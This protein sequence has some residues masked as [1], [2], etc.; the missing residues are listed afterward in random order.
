MA[1]I[2]IQDLGQS[3]TLD[4]K[5]MKALS[6]GLSCLSGSPCHDSPYLPSFEVPDINA[7]LENLMKGR[8][9]LEGQPPTDGPIPIEDGPG[10]PV[11][12]AY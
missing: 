5:A 1:K 11:Y 4:A 10:G 6:G 8:N 2:V 12:V 9:P 7:M 3:E